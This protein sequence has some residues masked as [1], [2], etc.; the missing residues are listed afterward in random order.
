MLLEEPVSPPTP[1]VIPGTLVVTLHMP[2]SQRPITLTLEDAGS[3]SP[4][5]TVLQD[6]RPVVLPAP[7]AVAPAV[8]RSEPVPE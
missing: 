6:D 5:V 3:E 1:D 8:S 2:G 7:K 4:G